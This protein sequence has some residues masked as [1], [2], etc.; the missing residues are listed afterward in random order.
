MGYRN[1]I[2]L[3]SNK[4]A[5]IGIKVDGKYQQLNSNVLQIENELYAPVRPKCVAKPNEK[6]SE[7]LEE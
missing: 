3:P 4:F 6:P 2:N 7:A 1:A 5:E